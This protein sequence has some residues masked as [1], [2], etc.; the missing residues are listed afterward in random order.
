MTLFGLRNVE[1]VL[2]GAAKDVNFSVS[3][4]LLF[5]TIC[6]AVDPVAVS[7]NINV[8]IPYFLE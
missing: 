3:S 6:A 7:I 4:A 5:G 8:E 1:V 2:T